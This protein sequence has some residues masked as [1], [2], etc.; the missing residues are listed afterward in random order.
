MRH[1]THSRRLVTGLAER[2]AVGGYYA[3]RTDRPGFSLIELLV[4]VAMVALLLAIL[5]PSLVRAR[6]QA[7]SV[8][9]L[10]NLRQM[11]TAAQTYAQGD[12]DRYPIAYA[13]SMVESTFTSYAWDFTTIR[14][15]NAGGT[16]VVAGL[17][18]QGKVDKDI[19]QCPSFRGNSNS[20]DDPR[21]GYNYNTSY[22]GH[23]TSESIVE[24]VRTGDV[25]KPFKCA[26]FGD[27]EYADGANKFMRAPW[28]NAGDDNFTGRSSGT[29]GFRHA[30]RTNVVFCDG[31]AEARAQRFTDTYA[32]DQARIA[33]GTGFLSK[34]NSAYETR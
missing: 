16:R 15:W 24:P 30:G 8:T 5:L 20:Q 13:Y 7:Q 26:L 33:P 4:V 17:L 1:A 11:A 27:G 28:R 21:T 32:A 25:R 31:H 34:D 22:I 6:G 23:G 2:R 18:W 3:L 14:D 29:Q 12:K 9:C 19:Q 10:S